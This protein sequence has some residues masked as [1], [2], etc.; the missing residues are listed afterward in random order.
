MKK[1]SDNSL[2]DDFMIRSNDFFEINYADI[3]LMIK[4]EYRMMG[5]LIGE[6]LNQNQ[7]DKVINEI[8]LINRFLK[9]YK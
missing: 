2:N 4:H 1:I 6:N 3:E 9:E 5:L 8:I 7:K